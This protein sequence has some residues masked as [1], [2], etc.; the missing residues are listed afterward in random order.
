MKIVVLTGSPR[1]NGNT[2]HLAGQF[3]KGAE[4]ARHEVYH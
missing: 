3:I 1:R 2:N 4:E